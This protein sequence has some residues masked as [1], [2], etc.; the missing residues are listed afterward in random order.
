MS[1][2]IPL[3]RNLIPY[4]NL[5]VNYCKNDVKYVTI[6]LH[7]KNSLAPIVEECQSKYKHCLI[8]GSIVPRVFEIDHF[9]YSSGS[10]L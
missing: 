7:L 10:G 9:E 5:G 8:L 1:K 2:G 3:G 6:M 4:I